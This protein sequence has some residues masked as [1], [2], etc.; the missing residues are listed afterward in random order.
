MGGKISLLKADFFRGFFL[1]SM[2]TFNFCF[3]LFMGDVF[4][5][6][7]VHQYVFATGIFLFFLGPRTLLDLVL[8]QQSDR[9]LFGGRRLEHCSPED[10]RFTSEDAL[11]VEPSVRLWKT[12]LNNRI[13]VIRPMWAIERVRWRNGVK[14]IAK[15]FERIAVCA[16][17]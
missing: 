17:P 8:S 9:R 4:A 11:A 16:V 6:P 2:S 10:Y 3:F 5:G 13:N 15:T 1:N 14:R 7:S 12:R